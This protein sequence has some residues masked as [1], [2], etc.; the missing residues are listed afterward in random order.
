MDSLSKSCLRYRNMTAEEKEHR[1]QVASAWR[2]K[3][4]PE[5]LKARH[6]AWITKKLEENPNYYKESYA[7]H[8][9]KVTAGN[10]CTAPRIE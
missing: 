5:K 6:K 1:K 10:N 8:K 4:D 3:Q 9:A 7:R 2:A